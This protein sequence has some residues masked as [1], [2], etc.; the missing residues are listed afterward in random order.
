MCYRS[1]RPSEGQPARKNDAL[2]S[3]ILSFHKPFRNDHS[4]AFRKS[5]LAQCSNGYKMAIRQ[6]AVKYRGIL[7]IFGGGGVSLP[8]VW[9]G[10]RCCGVKVEG[11]GVGVGVLPR[12]NAHDGAW[13]LS[14]F[15]PAR[16]AVSACQCRC[17]A[18]R[19]TAA[20]RLRYV[21]RRKTPTPT[22]RGGETIT[23]LGWW[24]ERPSIRSLRSLRHL[25]LRK[26]QERV[27]GLVHP[28]CVERPNGL[29][30]PEPSTYTKRQMRFCVYQG[31]GGQIKAERGVWEPV[32][33]GTRHFRIGITQEQHWR[34]APEQ[35]RSVFV[36]RRQ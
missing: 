2:A 23:S 12:R 4:K 28:W 7:F 20:F 34:R 3:V 1:V 26:A 16:S 31:M 33:A 25:R 11:Q 30:A 8:K 5:L 24:V 19:H 21:L 17:V 15:A 10:V 13:T 6:W 32:T 29:A 9:F 18:A 35:P 27:L 22:P 14:I 36:G